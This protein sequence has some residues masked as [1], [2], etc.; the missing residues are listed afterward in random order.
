MGWAA[1][2]GTARTP[3]LTA[4]LRGDIVPVSP[5]KVD[6]PELFALAR[7]VARLAGAYRR[8]ALAHPGG[9]ATLALYRQLASQVRAL[10][11]GGR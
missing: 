9:R 6:A 5:P 4:R 11:R 7:D 8:A 2:A 1:R 3:A 10:G